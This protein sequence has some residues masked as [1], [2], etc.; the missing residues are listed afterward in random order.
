MDQYEYFQSISEQISAH[1]V[2]SL[3]LNILKDMMPE[4]ET[5][6]QVV[7]ASASL[8]ESDVFVRTL[9]FTNSAGRFREAKRR[10]PQ[11]VCR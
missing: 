8:L 10:I 6:L 1:L 9:P 7:P 11:D 3:V 4:K 2:S 5:E